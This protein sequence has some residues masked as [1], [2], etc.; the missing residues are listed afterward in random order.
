MIKK[1]LYHLQ[2]CL[3]VR[4]LKPYTFFYTSMMKVTTKQ[5]SS[6][7]LDKLQVFFEMNDA[8]ND[9]LRSV[10]SLTNKVEKMRIN[11]KKQKTISDFFSNM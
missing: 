5:R 10:A 8:E 4:H 11:S 7:M 3:V 9:V 6:Y 1:D 2:T